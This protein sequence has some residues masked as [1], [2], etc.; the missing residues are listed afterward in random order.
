M[1]N[2]WIRYRLGEDIASSL[3]QNVRIV[4]LTGVGCCNC[5]CSNDGKCCWSNWI[6]RFNGAAYRSDAWASVGICKF[7]CSPFCGEVS[8][9]IGADVLGRLIQPGQEVP[10]G[11]MTAL[12]GGPWLLYLVWKTAKTHSR[13]DR[14]MGGTLKPVK[15]P[16]VVTIIVVLNYRDYV[17]CIFI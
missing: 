4:K 13:G 7:S 15:L 12:I 17:R 10:V 14:Q 6:Y 11:A 3:G 2:R 5:A 9:L 8:C 16:V 1:R